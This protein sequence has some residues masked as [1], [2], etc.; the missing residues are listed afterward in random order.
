MIVCDTGHES[1]SRY[2]P[3]RRQRRVRL[4]RDSNW[5]YLG[6]ALIPVTFLGWM[7]F[8]R[9]WMTEDA[10]ISL[11]VVHNILSGHGPVFNPGERVEAYTHP[12]WVALIAGWGFIGLPLEWGMV[13]LGLALSMLGLLGAQLA[14]A[15]LWRPAAQGEGADAQTFLFPLGAVA[16]AAVPIVWDFVTS[17]LETGLTF[18]WL[19]LTF[20]S[21]AR[22]CL[23][24]SSRVS[25]SPSLLLTAAVIGLGPL[26]RPD[27]AVFSAG[28]LVALIWCAWSRAAQGFWKRTFLIAIF[29]SWLP[30][31]YQIFRMGYFA[32]LVP[33]TALAKEAG[34]ARWGQGWV[35]LTDFT[36]TYHLWLPLAIALFWLVTLS[37]TAGRSQNHRRVIIAVV[38]VVSSVLHALYITRVGGDFMHGRMLL[39]S[40]FGML[41]PVAM[42]PLSIQPSTVWKRL[43][44][45]ASAVLIVWAAVSALSLR[46]PYATAISDQGI[47][48]ERAVYTDNAG[49]P[50]PITLDAY[51]GMRQ[52]WP[53]DGLAWKARADMGTRVL[54]IDDRQYALNASVDQRVD[55]AALAHNIGLAGVAAG[56]Q[57][58][59]VDVNGLADPFASR[60]KLTERGRPGHE[61]TLPVSWVVA[62][63][64][65]AEVMDGD[66]SVLAAR[67]ALECG[68][69]KELQQAV[70]DPLTLD[71]F[72]AN[73]VSSWLLHDLRIPADPADAVSRFCPQGR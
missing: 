33:N 3:E 35:Y 62:R 68:Q 52:S 72:F 53:R 13:I 47:A 8:E 34:E 5:L 7:G 15:R 24:P 49:Q 58:H 25:A 12:L 60:L 29:A 1:S 57:V 20:W 19:G 18:A 32:A 10:F 11:R 21:L 40:L 17:G 16:F 48:D 39:P 31:V 41:L 61:K 43:P 38:P 54:I 2:A 4:P 73:I 26:V 67:R 56:D 55:V 9:R 70:R 69:L 27:L 63:F 51:V 44:V 6:I 64:A 37:L 36:L 22:E 42:V 28:F 65:A 23:S 66:P 45:I 71:R 30:A 46:V 14:A 59:L 50:H